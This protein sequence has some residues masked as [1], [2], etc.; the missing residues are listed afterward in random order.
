MPRRF[1]LL[2][3]LFFASAFLVYFVLTHAPV[4]T[5]PNAPQSANSSA[6][7]PDAVRSYFRAIFGDQSDASSEYEDYVDTWPQDGDS[8]EQVIYAQPEMVRRAIAKLTPPTPGKVNLY[9]LAFAGDGEENVF[10]NE[11]EYVAKLFAQRFGATGHSLILA[12]NPD[13]LT[14]Y[15][16]A[17][18]SN[19]EVA[20]NG[21]AGKMDRDRDILM[22]FLTSHGSADHL[23]YVSMDPL[24]LDQI[25]PEDLAY[26]LAET[27]VRY[28]VVVISA[29][30][31]G[32]FVDALKSPTTLVITAARQDRTSFGC[33]TDSPITDFGRAFFVDGLNN[34]DSFTAAFST[35]SKLINQWETRDDEEHSHPQMA[36]APQIEAQLARWHRAIS[37]GPPVPFNADSKAPTAS[38]E[39]SRKK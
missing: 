38:S 28:K 27:H 17:S 21:V 36:S 37:L 7:D 5:P 8:P 16:L 20:A 18:L 32:G 35:A 23:L 12:N 1:F 3:I 34:T 4:I 30:Y 19:L 2:S 29:C 31:S 25:A 15:P 26:V 11:V 9:L 24:P 33:G 14:R 22:L 6:Q 13:T 39:A 10:V